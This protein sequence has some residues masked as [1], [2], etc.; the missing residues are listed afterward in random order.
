MVTGH[1]L[2]G[3]LASLASIDIK[4]SFGIT[5]KVITFGQPRIGNQ[6]LANYLSEMI[7]K[8]YRVIN[9]ADIVPHLPTS[10]FNYAHYG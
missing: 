3:A 9:Y 7:P 8:T 4:N 6:N 2:G 5:P 10:T 1:S